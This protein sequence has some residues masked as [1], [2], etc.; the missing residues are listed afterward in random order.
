M[1]RIVLAAKIFF[2]GFC[3]LTPGYAFSA[4]IPVFDGSNVTQTTVSA[5]E[6]VNQTLKQLEEYSTQLQ[7]YE[8]Q[9]KNSLAPAA[10]VWSK[11]QQTIG[12]IQ[13]LQGEIMAIYSSAGN[14]EQYLQKF[15]DVN[16]YKDSPYFNSE[17]GGTKSQLE[18]LKE[19]EKAGL[20][21]QKKAYEGT[22]R[23]LQQQQ[24]QLKTDAEELRALTGTAETAQGRM[25]A[26]QYA[27]Q[28]A[29]LQGGQLLQLRAT[30]QSI[31]QSE[32]ARMQTEQDK[33]SRRMAKEEALR[34]GLGERTKVSAPAIS[35][36]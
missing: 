11:A 31:H 29:S 15:G 23:T 28:F 33:E 20:E 17:G 22:A 35:F 24:E 12:K 3:L 4:G 5:L 13:D 36:F 34:K 30:L 16:Y 18:Q 6:N 14:L 26:M 32:L 10:Y 2:I 7:Q 1:K 19:G 27:N 25:E 8:D 9:L 21:L